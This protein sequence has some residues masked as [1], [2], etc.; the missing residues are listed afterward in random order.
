MDLHAQPFDLKIKLLFKF[1]DD[2][3]ADIAEG[4]YVIG[5]DLKAYGHGSDLAFGT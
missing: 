4:S 3:F 2:A 5:K 1:F